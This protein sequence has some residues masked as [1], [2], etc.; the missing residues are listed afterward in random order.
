MRRLSVHLTREQGVEGRS[1]SIEIRSRIALFQAVLLWGSIAWRTLGTGITCLPSSELTGDAEVNQ[2]NTPF[3][4][5][6]DVG[7][8]HIA[9]DNRRVPAMQVFKNLTYLD[10]DVEHLFE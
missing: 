2:D 8:F 1:E 6:H 9:I 3:W 5:T 7:G 4:R 10:T